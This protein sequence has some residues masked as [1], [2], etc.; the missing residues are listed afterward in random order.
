MR[1]KAGHGNGLDQLLMLEVE[2]ATYM[3]CTLLDA[4]VLAGRNWRVGEINLAGMAPVGYMVR[5][6][7]KRAAVQGQVACAQET[8]SVPEQAYFL[9]G[10]RQIATL[11]GDKKAI[12]LFHSVL[13]Y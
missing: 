2:V 5:E 12:A 8:C 6:H 1:V 7:E 10:S 4:I 11:I 13:F 3:N 9:V